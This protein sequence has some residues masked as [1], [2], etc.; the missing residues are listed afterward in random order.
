MQQAMSFVS[1]LDQQSNSLTS[2]VAL[3]PSR[4]KIRF[5]FE[6]LTFQSKIRPFNTVQVKLKSL[7]SS[8]RMILTDLSILQQNLTT[9]GT[10]LSTTLSCR[11]L[12]AIM[13]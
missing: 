2:D 3:V 9:D 6:Q 1:L 10:E 12:T 4:L 5:G 11:S 8:L 7:V 13:E